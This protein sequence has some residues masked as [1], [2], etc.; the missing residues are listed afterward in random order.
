MQKTYQPDSFFIGFDLP[1]GTNI[2]FYG[3]ITADNSLIYK[4]KRMFGSAAC[5]LVDLQILLGS[6][7]NENCKVLRFVC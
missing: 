2:G 4:I 6:A 3:K 5:T 1:K 7:D